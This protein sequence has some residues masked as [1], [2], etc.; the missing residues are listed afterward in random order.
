MKPLT[1][2]QAEILAFIQ[3]YW[4]EN[5]FSPALRDIGIMFGITFRS[6][7]DHLKA[8]QK[9]GYIRKTPG[10]ARSIVIL[11]QPEVCE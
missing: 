7:Q 9:K 3:D 4:N 11:K 6:V 1:D 5:G 10:I 8:I 2:R